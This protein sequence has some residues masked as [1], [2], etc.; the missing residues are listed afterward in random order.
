ML[1]ITFEKFEQMDLTKEFYSDNFLC[2][3]TFLQ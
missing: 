2:F 1:S 3:T